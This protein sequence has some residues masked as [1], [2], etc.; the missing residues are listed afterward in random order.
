MTHRRMLA[1]GAWF[2][3]LAL[4][5]MGTAWADDPP[6]RAVDIRYISGQVS[7]QPGGV[8]DWVAAV[9]NRPLTTAD[10]VWTDT[11]ARAELHLGTASLRLNAETSLTLTNVDD[12]TVQVELDQGTL[13]LRV[14]HMYDGEIYE[15]DTPNLAFTLTQTGEYR[16]DV[17]SNGDATLVTVWQGDGQATGD[18]NAVDVQTGQQARF[19]NGTSLQNEISSAPGFDG[20]DDWC[21]VRDD[22][23]DRSVSARYVS[24]NVIGYEELDDYG[25]WRDVPEYGA[26]WVP[27][28]VEPD[29]APYHYGHWVWV[30]PWGWTWVDD[31]PWGF[32]PAHYGRWVYTGGFWGWAPGPVVVSARPVYAPALVAWVG[33]AHWGAGISFSG[34]AGVAWFPLGYNEPYIPPYTVSRAYF[35]QVNVTNIHVTNVTVINNYY[36]NTAVVANIH[37]ANRTVPGAF[38]AV[39]AGA[40]A[41]A[42]PVAR[43]AVRVPPAEVARVSVTTTAVVAPSRNAVL[44]LHAGVRAAAPPA[45]VVSRTVVMRA[46]PPPK[47]IPFAAKQAALAQNPGKPLDAQAT[48]QIRARN[49]QLSAPPAYH[50]AKA[51]PARPAT[52]AS[53][54]PSR[55]MAPPANRPPAAPANAA[56]PRPAN[57]PA[58]ANTPPARN[59]PR[60]PNAGAP[61][62]PERN[63]PAQPERNAPPAENR[64][65][66]QSPQ[67]RTAPQPPANRNVP[68]PPQ[69]NT[70]RPAP[71]AEQHPAARPNEP[72]HPNQPAHAA[73]SQNKPP[74][75]KKEP[76]PKK[77]EKADHHD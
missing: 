35:T 40:L 75:N 49:P 11:G 30:D 43:V 37:Y 2:A 56:P 7:V 72:P 9:V 61:A 51:P 5:L 70:Q 62:Q 77:E 53:N 63:A 18:G 52:P 58:N 28:H 42:Q 26:V 27:A 67:N 16:F 47:P 12:Q 39:P 21:R 15:V 71:P 24:P 65:T 44:G 25:S 57:P 45:R 13:G 38:T 10:R 55:P 54:V 31:A 6:G 69:Q 74:Q 59:V 64:A 68:R 22:R 1:S 41:G 66:P 34:G 20:F 60:P 23:E 33:G 8:D 32:A 4:V 36:N 14:R 17:D 3:L 46:P 48:Q 19:T 76:P 29:W 50:A 73:P